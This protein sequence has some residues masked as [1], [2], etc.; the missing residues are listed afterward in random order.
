MPNRCA[1][2]HPC[3]TALVL[4]RGGLG[5][6]TW[7]PAAIMCREHGGCERGTWPRRLQ[8]RQAVRIDLVRC[9]SA[10]KLPQQE[11]YQNRGG[12]I[13]TAARDIKS[14]ATFKMELEL[15][16]LSS[17][18]CRI[19][20]SAP[21]TQLL[22]D[23][24]SRALS[25]SCCGQAA[26]PQANPAGNRNSRL[27][28]NASSSRQAAIQPPSSGHAASNAAVLRD[29]SLRTASIH[30]HISRSSGDR[31][32]SHAMCACRSTCAVRY[33]ATDDSSFARQQLLTLS[34]PRDC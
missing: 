34:T 30:G 6:V 29:R 26:L 33:G 23:P 19:G 25:R 3:V 27:F 9:S 15:A 12:C 28:G 11:Q 13:R 8:M 1:R 17:L 4:H 22:L 5:P 18:T 31:S 24:R 21:S 2:Y 32:T 16:W 20:G 7:R 14:F 10:F